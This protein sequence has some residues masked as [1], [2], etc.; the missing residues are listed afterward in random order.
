MLKEEID[1]TWSR[2]PYPVGQMLFGPQAA[3]TLTAI[4]VRDIT[5][6][7]QSICGNC[8]PANDG[9][10]FLYAIADG[11]AAAKPLVAYS[12]D[13]GQTWTQQTITVGSQR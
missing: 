3:G 13:G 10:K 7:N 12:V 4:Q 6:G 11:G 2:N 1:V 9:T 8:G 5:Y